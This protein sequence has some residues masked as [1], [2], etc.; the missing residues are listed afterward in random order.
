MRHGSI[1]LLLAAT[2][3]LAACQGPAAGPVFSSTAVAPV[4]ASLAR[5]YFYRDWEPYDSMSRPWI[6]LNEARSDISEPGGVSY[7]DVTPGDYS[8][9]VD[10]PGTYPHQFKNLSLR[11][12]DIRYVKIELLRNWYRGPF[13]SCDTFVVELIPEQQA[14][15]EIGGMHYLPHEGAGL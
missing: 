13:W 11:A 5:V 12:G 15:A 8:I 7:R 14:R 2:L 1:G 4:G 10:S 6:Y 9:T 3:A